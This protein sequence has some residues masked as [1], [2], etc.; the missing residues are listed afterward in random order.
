MVL[1]EHGAYG[2]EEFVDELAKK[3]FPGDGFEW[4][5]K[6]RSIIDFNMVSGVIAN[7]MVFMDH[8][9]VVKK[10]TPF[11]LMDSMGW[12]PHYYATLYVPNFT[13]KNDWVETKQI[14]FYKLMKNVSGNRIEV[15]S[16]DPDIQT[17]GFA[18]GSKVFV[19]L[20]NLSDYPH[21]LNLTIPDPITKTRVSPP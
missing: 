4:E 13:D 15:H 10:A 12:D 1:S 2:A 3:H 16:P 7:T 18:N 5:M 6:K 17:Q 8:P 11:I 14:F 19:L 20:N 21:D 9:H